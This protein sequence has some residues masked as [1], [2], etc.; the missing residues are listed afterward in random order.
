DLDAAEGVILLIRIPLVVEVVQQRDGAPVVLVFAEHPRVAA[1]GCLDGEHVFAQALALRMFGNDG[2]GLVSREAHLNS[3][4]AQLPT[5]NEL[6][7]ANSQNSQD[8]KGSL[9][10]RD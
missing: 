8:K 5:S 4:T 1:H 7:S 2:P 10:F 3:S 6:P 9:S